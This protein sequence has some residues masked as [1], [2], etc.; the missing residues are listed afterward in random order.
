MTHRFPG[1]DPDGVAIAVWEAQA[2]PADPHLTTA[3][4]AAA[5]VARGATIL[6]R[7]EVASL[8]E[9][10]REVTVT[11][12]DGTRYG[13]GRLLIA[14]G[15][16]T[17]R[18][19]AQL[20][21]D[22]PLH[23]ER[24]IV[25]VLGEDPGGARAP[26]VIIDVAAGYY[27]APQRGGQTLL[28]ALDPAPAADPDGRIEPVGD[29]EFAWLAEAY[30]SRVPAPLPGR[31]AGGWASLYD[32]SPDW[33]PVVGRIGERVFVDAGTSGHGFKLAPA[34]GDHVAGLL[35]DEPPDPALAQFDPGRFAAGARLAGGFGTA[36]ILG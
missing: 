14:A 6:S 31:R 32:V 28:G 13:C 17:S 35:A 9:G 24:H 26:F 21:V 27:S 19:T 12:T 29:A 34:L 22:L 3:G 30:T 8:D 7:T 11:T 20:G 5:A 18:L 23:A 25:G 15:P 4:L 2:G 33:Q 1:V 10:P 16:W 36:R